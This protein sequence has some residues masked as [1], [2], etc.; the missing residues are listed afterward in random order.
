M[1]TEVIIVGGGST[2][3]TLAIDLGLR[4]VRAVLTSVSSDGI[5]VAQRSESE[6]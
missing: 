3:L 2:G 1:D 6:K 5:A 4:G